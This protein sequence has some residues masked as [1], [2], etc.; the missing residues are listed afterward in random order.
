MERCCN[1]YSF[2]LST[3]YSREQQKEG[4]KRS[5]S[6]SVSPK[7]SKHA[8]GSS[9]SCFSFWRFRIGTVWHLTALRT[10][11]INSKH[12]FL[13]TAVHLA[14]ASPPPGTRA[15]SS[16][17]SQAGEFQCKKPSFAVLSRLQS[18]ADPCQS[19]FPGLPTPPHPHPHACSKQVSEK[20]SFGA[21][22]GNM[23]DIHCMP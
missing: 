20:N 2:L 15:H 22:K 14:P 18:I 16:L 4:L 23:L 3:C 12:E 10:L 6:L 8:M 17:P 13:Q 11:Q 7:L 21:L 5:W 9:L 1:I 19:S